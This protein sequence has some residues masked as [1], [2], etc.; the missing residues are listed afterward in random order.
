[1]RIVINEEFA[2]GTDEHS[3][4]IEK[5]RTRKR[6]G[7]MVDEWSA[8]SWHTSPQAAVNSLADRMIRASE[9]QTLTKALEDVKNVSATLCQ[10]LQ[11]TFEVKPRAAIDGPQS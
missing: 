9:A 1:M 3:W 2:L 10:A 6:R 11:P 5:H 4:T 8:I 7:K